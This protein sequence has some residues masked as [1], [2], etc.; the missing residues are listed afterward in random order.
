M[1]PR[2]EKPDTAA[3]A[4]TPRTEAALRWM[5]GSAVEDELLLEVGRRVR[6]R[7]RRQRLGA[8]VAACLAM[9]LAFFSWRERR[10][11]DPVPES[12][13]AHL[14]SA[15]PTA[16][17]L[18][19]RREVLPDG[20]V[21]ELKEGAVI[22][23]AFRADRRM[24]TL[25]RGEAHF[26]V[27]KDAARPFVV[28]AGGVEARAV[29]TAFSVKL[30]AAAVEVLVSEGRVAVEAAARAEQP[31]ALL[32]RGGLARV[33]LQT[34][35]TRTAVSAVT[36][37]ELAQRLAWRVPQLEFSQTPLPEIVRLMNEHGGEMR[38]T[39]ELSAAEAAEIRLS[40]FLAA[41][42]VEGLVGLLEANF[43]LRAQR[44][45]GAVR[46]LRR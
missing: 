9:G 28:T 14:A 38:L 1:T 39:L 18:A 30:Q 29:G 32:E 13:A 46:L 4:D 40:G 45:D 35:E 16:T 25:L 2:N 37:G 42:N 15:T 19:P 23:T 33:E 8:G 5:Q 21:V 31:A 12:G 41:D 11:V 26:T 6:A 10:T 7:R 24:V 44:A 27:E 3:G 22:E 17:V 34:A 43:P 20:S 36:P